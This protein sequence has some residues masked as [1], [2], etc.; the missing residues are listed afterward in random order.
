MS[1]TGT[2]GLVAIAA[3]ARV[4]TTM[5]AD[6]SI[7]ANFGKRY[8]RLLDLAFVEDLL[9]T[10]VFIVGAELVLEGSVGGAVHLSL[11]SVAKTAS[12]SLEA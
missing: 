6:V 7:T 5:L 2:D 4:L 10:L 9:D 1:A 12:A 8:L 11:R 3:T